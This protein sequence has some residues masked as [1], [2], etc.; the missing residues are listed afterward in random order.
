MSRRNLLQAALIALV[1]L[2][3][4]GNAPAADGVAAR[5]AAYR[6]LLERLVPP[7]GYVER[8]LRRHRGEALAAR[9][10]GLV[11]QGLR[12]EAVTELRRA[13]AEDPKAVNLG[14]RALVLAAETGDSATARALADSL[15][16]AAP[17]FAPA[18]LHRGLARQSLGDPAGAAEDFRVAAASTALVPADAAF[19]AEAR[20]EALVA[21]GDDRGALAALDSLPTAQTPDP[22][23]LLRKARLLER[24]GNRRAAED[25]FAAARDAAASGAPV[26]AEAARGLIALLLRRGAVAEA[27]E[28][29][30]RAGPDAGDSDTV[31]R[32]L[33]QAA[34]AAGRPDVAEP[35]LRI[36]MNRVS[37]AER[38]RTME[39]LADLLTG[40]GRAAEAETLLRAA[41]ETAAERD[42]RARLLERAGHAGMAANRPSAAFEDFRAA[43]ADMATPARLRATMASGLAAGRATEVATL[44]GP[45]L[46]A[47]SRRDLLLIGLDLARKAGRTDQAT[48][49]L[50]RLVA[51]GLA[52]SRDL[53]DLAYALDRADRPMDALTQYQAAWQAAPSAETA[54]ALGLAL[55]RNGQAE[56]ARA[57]LV[58]SL[59]AGRRRNALPPTE[60][61]EVEATLGQI[62]F[63]QGRFRD[64]AAHWLAADGGRGDPALRLRQARALVAAGDF[65][66][67]GGALDGVEPAS[68]FDDADRADWFAIASEAAATRRNPKAA[69]TF[70]FRAIDARPTADRLLRLAVLC[71]LV[72]RDDDATAALERAA[73]L[74][75]NRYQV[76]EALAYDRVAHQ[77]WD[78]AADLFERALPLEPQ[79][80]LIAEDIGHLAARRGNRARALT[81]FS[82]AVDGHRIVESVRNIEPD[83]ATK[84]LYRL[85]RQ[86]EILDR[87]WSG[88]IYSAGC[89]MTGFC[90]QQGSAIGDA[91]SEGQGGA[92]LAWRP[93]EIGYIDGRIF[94]A[95]GRLFWNARDGGFTP[96]PDSLQA[97]VGVRY[98][99]LR[100]H[101]LYIHA[102]R[103]F[104]VGRKAENN[105]LARATWGMSS[106]LDIAPLE[107]PLSPYYSLYGDLGQFLA[108]NQRTLAM[109]EG[110]V[111]VKVRPPERFFVAP[112]VSFD[113]RDTLARNRH[114]AVADAGIGVS[115]HGWYSES[116]HHA[117]RGQV[118]LEP[119]LRQTVYDSG[120][121]AD[122]RFT[123]TLHVLY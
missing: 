43:W 40:T 90:R 12:A 74:A 92:E 11:R 54:K 44:D 57:M 62:A 13:F 73:A 80:V 100:D 1:W 101:D 36:L 53:L 83:T 56:P 32:A 28:A 22:G 31:D 88:S 59:K 104:A 94:E 45:G 113:V 115:L 93:P 8:E 24:S 110:R 47:T 37:P 108:G 15:L 72:H 121:R 39:M 4:A 70:L 105:W 69:T 77:R 68:G 23:H 65:V 52:R 89:A 29:I 64:A 118:L 51:L 35:R 25:A 112:F 7:A 63:A 19:A 122:L 26:A 55:F 97:G 21:A 61:P 82:Q 41:A 18:R 79:P 27:N 95:T 78:E 123:I 17:D 34:V 6:A 10:D 96:D 60:R 116:D 119:R 16:A 38:G 84:E 87:D 20:V 107:P 9:A 103:L 58:R 3:V 85:R 71:R 46:D 102:E 76:L 67:A 30:R 14:W 91:R 33:A 109:A 42:E 99:P 114:D 66:A 106:D 111:G 49:I 81:A 50:S 117:A 5:D 48:A 98:K 75:P 86:I 2:T 120:G